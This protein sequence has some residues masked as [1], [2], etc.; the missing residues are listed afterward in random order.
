MTLFSLRF[1]SAYA[2]VALVLGAC[3][4][5]LTAA[6]DDVDGGPDAAFPDDAAKEATIIPDASCDGLVPADYDFSSPSPAGLTQ[7]PSDGGTVTIAD[8]AAVFTSVNAAK[9]TLTRRFDL[10]ATSASLGYTFETTQPEVYIEMG[11]YLAFYQGDDE[12]VLALVTAMTPSQI[13]LDDSIK[14]TPDAGGDS[15]PFSLLS[16]QGLSDRH[17]I[18]VDIP[19]LEPGPIVANVRVDGMSLGSYATS[20]V[21]RPTSIGLSCGI[22]DQPMVT[23]TEKKIAI[24]DVSVRLCPR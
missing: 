23:S 13:A 22:E 1:A 6:R 5:T 21:A 19:S 18:E 8:G 14:P 9:A 11:C 15:D 10:A 3:G 2:A 17:R 16:S 24:D 4:E 7:N 20:L 12:H